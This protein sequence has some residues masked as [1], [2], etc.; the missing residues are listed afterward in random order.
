MLSDGLTSIRSIQLVLCSI[1]PPFSRLACLIVF[2]DRQEQ[3]GIILPLAVLVLEFSFSLR[4]GEG[5]QPV[6]RGV[7]AHT[8][9]N[10]FRRLH[11]EHGFAIDNEQFV[12]SIV[13]LGT[14][15]SFLLLIPRLEDLTC[16]RSRDVEPLADQG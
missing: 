1:L 10:I 7:L 16:P 8:G 2:L 3:F 9:D 5:V 13:V 11:V 15:L 14:L 12:G 6:I 4:D